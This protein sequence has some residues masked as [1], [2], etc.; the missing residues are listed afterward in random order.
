VS[1]LFRRLEAL[2]AKTPVTADLDLSP[3]AHAATL[4][5]MLE[6]MEAWKVKQAA[7][8]AMSLE[9]RKAAEAQEEAAY[10]RQVEAGPRLAVGC[11]FSMRAAI[12]AVMQRRYS[13]EDAAHWSV[14]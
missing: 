13:P 12:E 1:S 9:G 8:E 11:R 2:E 6:R 7:L 5:R 3:E 10:W 4:Q 14:S